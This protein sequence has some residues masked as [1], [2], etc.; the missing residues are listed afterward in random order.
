[1]TNGIMLGYRY[2][3]LGLVLQILLQRNNASCL[4]L[5]AQENEMYPKD[6]V[7]LLAHFKR[8]PKHKEYA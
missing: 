1:M 7:L 2:L 5:L 6:E 3:F 4:Y 8:L